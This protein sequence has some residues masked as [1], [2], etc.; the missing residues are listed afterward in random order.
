MKRYQIESVA[1]LAKLGITAYDITALR[2]IAGK[3]HRWA[4]REAN[5][6]VCVEDDGKAYAYNVRTGEMVCRTANQEGIAIARLRLVMESYPELA[7]YVQGDPRGCPL[8][9]YRRADL[10]G[11]DIETCY[12]SVGVPVQ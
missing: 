12:P 7:A 11:R 9:V 8:Y 6:E 4:E 3:L 5:G 10:V 1:A 2:R